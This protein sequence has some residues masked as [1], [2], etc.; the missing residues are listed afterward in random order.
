MLKLTSQ[1]QG[2]RMLP[3]EKHRAV[4]LQTQTTQL[5]KLY[6]PFRSLY[7]KWNSKEH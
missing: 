1:A 5:I 3:F 6:R 2:K 7:L 4:Q